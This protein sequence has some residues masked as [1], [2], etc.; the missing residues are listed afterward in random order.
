MS[1]RWKNAVIAVSSDGAANMTGKVSGLVTRLQAVCTPG[2]LRIW[3]GLHQFDLVMQRVYSSAMDDMFYSTLTGLIGHLRRQ[4]ILIGMM[5]ST[6]HKVA[7]TRWLSMGAVTKWLTKHHIR[8]RQ[9][10]VTKAPA[11]APTES[12]WCVL[13]IIHVIATEATDVFS[14]LQGRD[15]LLEQQYEM[16]QDLV[17]L[18]CSMS[19]MVGLSGQPELETIVELEPAEVCGTYALTVENASICMDGTSYWVCEAMAE[20]GKYNPREVERT[21]RS[22]AR[23]FA[24]AADGISLIVAERDESNEPLLSNPKVLPYQLVKMDMISFSAVLKQHRPRLLRHYKL[25]EHVEAIGGEFLQLQRAYRKEKSLR[26]MVKG[27]EK[28]GLSFQ[29]SWKSIHEQFPAVADFCTEIACAFPNT[30][31]VESDFSMIGVE[32]NEYRTSLTDFSLEG[33]LHCKQYETLTA[34]SFH[35]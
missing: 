1:S 23:V 2:M 8:I 19:G 12:W 13:F 24:Q 20:L 3:C 31:T 35:F 25:Q 17:H 15:T 10:L 4:P 29:E 11:S 6:C 5:Q 7:S 21:A 9:H 14:A 16:L 27:A 32:K 22:T 28:S 34:L 26:E 30:A 18:Y 33:I